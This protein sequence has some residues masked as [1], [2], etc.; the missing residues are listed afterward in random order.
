MRVKN[1]FG[2]TPATTVRSLAA[3]E[4][5]AVFVSPA[6]GVTSTRTSRFV[7][8]V[9]WL[10]AEAGSSKF[11]VSVSFARL[12]AS[13][14]V[15]VA[16]GATPVDGVISVPLRKTCTT[17]VTPPTAAA[18]P[19]TPI[20]ARTAVLRRATSLIE[21]SG[22]WVACVTST[23]VTVRSTARAAPG[24]HRSAARTRTARR[25]MT[26]LLRYASSRPYARR[27]TQGNLIWRTRSLCAAGET[28]D[29]SG[30][31]SWVADIALT[32]ARALIERTVDKAQDIGVRGAVVVVGSSG[33]LVSAS[34][35][36][37]GGAGGM[38][39]ARSK[40]WIAA[41]QQMPS[42][43]HLDRMRT[44]PAPMSAGFVICSPEAAF[45]GAGGMPL[46]GGGIAASGATVG[47]FVTYPGADPR[48]L[49]A[50]GKP[51]NAEDLLVHY[52]LEREYAGQHG[53]DEARW[54]DA[55]GALP[56]E[57]GLGMAD[58]P[59]AVQPELDAARA[60]AD[61]A[62]EEARRRGVK[63]AVAIVDRRGEPIQQDCMDGAPTAAPFVAEAVAAG[64]AT[65]GVPSGDVPAA[66]VG[67]LPYR[68]AVLPGGLPL[69]GGGIGVAGV[70]PALAHDIAAAVA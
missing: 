58:A 36:D 56:D 35:M 48:K 3:P 50:G 18:L 24:N 27:F 34:R 4:L 45:P 46:E 25:S 33:V 39:R 32:D 21:L 69:P 44:L 61:R 20:V 17:P 67:V 60:L 49:I 12:G 40:A 19:L 66:A 31:L 29:S 70:A 55:Y 23:P 30:S 52:A 13:G 42:L 53:D 28:V 59:R 8:A 54:I 10:S 51:A 38:A 1:S 47:P 26:S 11:S 16:S 62:I 64:A 43:V 41:R 22:F 9:S 68:V 37:R 65:F 6:T 15:S 2:F 14:A 57:P 7:V 63:I 5:L